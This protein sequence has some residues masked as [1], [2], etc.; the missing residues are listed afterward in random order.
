MNF[1]K[2]KFGSSVSQIKKQAKAYEAMT[3]SELSDIALDLGFESRQNESVLPLV[4]RGFALVQVAA[5][6]QLGMQH[7]DVQLK[8]GEAMCRGHV[9]EMQTGEGKT[10]TATLPMFVHALAGKGAMLALSLIHI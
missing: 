1:A 2:P 9:A 8:G 4:V 10:L 3:D 7:Y 5:K 6:R